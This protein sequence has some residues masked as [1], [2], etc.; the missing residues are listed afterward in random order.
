MSNK[1][2]S[3]IKVGNNPEYMRGKLPFCQNLMHV[4]QSNSSRDDNTAA[5]RNFYHYAES[6]KSFLEVSQ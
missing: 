5:G 6:A 2:T 4:V 1:L 3:F